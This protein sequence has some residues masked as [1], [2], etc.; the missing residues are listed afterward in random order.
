MTREERAHVWY[1]CGSEGGG[2][3]FTTLPQSGANEGASR[4]FEVIFEIG[5]MDGGAV[6]L[7][8]NELFFCGGAP[9][10]SGVSSRDLVDLSLLVVFFLVF[11]I[12]PGVLFLFFGAFLFVLEGSESIG[13]VCSA[14]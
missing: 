8:D 7:R 12:P 13:N 11:V 9:P 5:G 3:D 2:E 6:D 14:S 1:G 4:V 10:R